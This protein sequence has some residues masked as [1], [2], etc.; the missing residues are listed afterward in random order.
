SLERIQKLIGSKIQRIVKPGFEVT[1]RGSLLK[2]LSRKVITGRSNR[3]SETVIELESTGQVQP[4]G[5]PRRAK[6]SSEPNKSGTPKP[7]RLKGSNSPK[8]TGPKKKVL[9][10]KRAKQY[11]G[12]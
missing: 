8:N 9:R 2:S 6:V 11:Q 12:K 3:A 4:K 1:S 5:K 7:V 10:G